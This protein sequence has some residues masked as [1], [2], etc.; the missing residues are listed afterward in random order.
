M[1]RIL[2]LTAAI[3]SG[4]ACIFFVYNELRLIGVNAAGAAGHKQPRMAIDGFVFPFASF[5]L[6]WISL[7]C[8]RRAGV[9]PARH[10]EEEL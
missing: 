4:V 5:Y 9:L 7:E 10:P 2:F 3:A 1:M 6:G 8:F